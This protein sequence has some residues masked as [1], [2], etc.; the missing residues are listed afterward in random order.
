MSNLET[1]QK[2]ISSLTFPDRKFF[3]VGA[4]SDEPCW[5]KSKS[6]P[7]WKKFWLKIDDP[8]KIAPIRKLDCPLGTLS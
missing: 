5:E 7:T 6:D 8:E 1:Q 3:R 4:E 2:K